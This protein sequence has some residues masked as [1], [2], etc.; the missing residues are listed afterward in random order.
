MAEPAGLKYSYYPGCS[1]E[2]T[3]LEYNLSARVAAELLGVELVELE[4]WS[5]CGA[6]SGHCINRELSLALPARNLALAE[7]AGNDMAVAC[8]A[9]F[10]RFRQTNHDLRADPALLKQIGEII[11]T[12]YQAR[13]DVRHL[14]D[15]FARMVG[16]EEVARRV[17]KPLKGLKLACYYGCYLVRPPGVTEFDDPENPTIMDRL[18]EAAGAECLDWTHK[19]DCC[20]GSHLLARTD[21]VAKLVGDI[22]Q[23]ATDAGADA[24]VAACP[25]CLANIDMR[26][27]AGVPVFYFSELLALALGANTGQVKKWLKRHINDPV[28]VLNRAKLL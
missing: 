26:E 3:A 8:A 24:I 13:T 27:T 5:C 19:V 17:K 18:M 16:L 28:P 4:D 23:A 10:L 9:C 7:K 21:I 20:G 6:S 25:L 2:A 12:P 22:C 11:G 15:I 1:L 14:V